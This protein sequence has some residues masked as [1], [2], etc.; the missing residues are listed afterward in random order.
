MSTREGRWRVG[1]IIYD[2][3]PLAEIEDRTW[4]TCRS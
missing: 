3:N 4:L 1:T 2:V